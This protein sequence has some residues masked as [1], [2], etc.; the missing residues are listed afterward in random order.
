MSL[1]VTSVGR[2][3]LHKELW[4]ADIS[5]EPVRKARRRRGAELKIV[6]K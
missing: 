4:M 2:Q 6:G 5:K 1:Y 3:G